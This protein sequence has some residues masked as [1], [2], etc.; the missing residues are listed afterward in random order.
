[1]STLGTF[2]THWVVN[3]LFLGVLAGLAATWAPCSPGLRVEGEG[4]RD[5]SPQVW[6]WK[7]RFWNPCTPIL[8]PLLVSLRTPGSGPPHSSA[9]L[10]AFRREMAPKAEEGGL[11][12]WEM[13]R[14]APHCRKPRAPR[15]PSRPGDICRTP[16]VPKSAGEEEPP[17]L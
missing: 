11:P 8:P 6:R 17:L 2:H 3:P 16:A 5:E 14:S 7:G 10:T 4:W 9:P 1:M 15:G 12:A 13:P